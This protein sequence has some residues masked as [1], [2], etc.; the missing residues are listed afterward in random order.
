MEAEELGNT[1]IKPAEGIG[2]A[3]R[4]KEAKLIAFAEV[5]GAGAHVA[6]CIER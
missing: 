5:N 4:P 2:K 3:Q 1:G 6:A